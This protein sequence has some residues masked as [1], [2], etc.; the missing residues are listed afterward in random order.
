M[1]PRHQLHRQP[2]VERNRRSLGAGVIDDIGGGD[3]SRLRGNGD[4]HAVV[5][6]DH[7]RQELARKPVVREGVDLELEA[8]LRLGA[9]EDG[10]AGADAGVVDEDGGLA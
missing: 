9:A 5:A 3:V 2:L 4:D 10:L 7:V 6:V 8:G 1:V